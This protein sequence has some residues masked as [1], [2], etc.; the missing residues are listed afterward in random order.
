MG[1][2]EASMTTQSEIQFQTETLQDAKVAPQTSTACMLIKVE[3]TKM[4]G[5]SCTI[6]VNPASKLSHISGSVHER[7]GCP[8]SGQ[9]FFLGTTPLLDANATFKELGVVDGAALTVVVASEPLGQHLLETPSGK[10]SINEKMKPSEALN[11]FQ[12]QSW[13]AAFA[14]DQSDER[15]WADF[16]DE[17]DAPWGDIGCGGVDFY[18][19]T[20]SDG[21]RY[22]YWSTAPGDNEYGILVRVDASSL[23]VIG[24][25]SDDGLELLNN[26]GDELRND[27]IEEQL[28]KEGW[29]RFAHSDDEDEED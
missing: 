21:C 22:E 14:Y 27:E 19:T 2:C 6:S 15:I 5:E 13:R 1:C 4:G 23:K 24:T 10:T 28:L 8:L 12:L 3:V 9:K 11:E 18:W 26:K 20:R 25:G 16:Y 17:D 29:P 7:L